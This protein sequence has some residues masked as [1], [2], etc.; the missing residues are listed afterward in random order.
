LAWK[1]QAA[2]IAVARTIMVNTNHFSWHRSTQ[3][4]ICH[5][6]SLG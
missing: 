5:L 3:R 4:L 1:Q 6:S 2:V